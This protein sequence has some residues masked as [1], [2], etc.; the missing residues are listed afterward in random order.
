[1]DI[2]E[3]AATMG[4]PISYERRFQSA[5]GW[6]VRN[7]FASVTKQQQLVLLSS[8]LEGRCVVSKPTLVEL[9][10]TAEG[11]SWFDLRKKLLAEGWTEGSISSASIEGKVFHKRNMLKQYL[12]LLPERTLE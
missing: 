6:L 7:G 10:N 11:S 8:C 9:P 4:K 3:H 5:V 12:E 1:M 2:G